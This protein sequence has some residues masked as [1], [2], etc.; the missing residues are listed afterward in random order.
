M[1][2]IDERHKAEDF[3]AVIDPYISALNTLRG[4]HDLLVEDIMEI[5]AALQVYGHQRQDTVNLI[6]AIDASIAV[7]Y[8]NIPVFKVK[9]HILARLKHEAEEVNLGVT[10][11]TPVEEA[12]SAT[13]ELGDIEDK[14]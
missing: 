5:D 12:S 3:L 6:A 1:S 9:P 2:L 8:P 11:F 10:R 4:L 7:G 14:T 13:I